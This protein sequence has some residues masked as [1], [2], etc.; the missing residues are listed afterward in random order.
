[1]LRDTQGVTVLIYDQQCAAEA[2]RKRKRGKLP[3]RRTRVVINEAVC[4]GCGDCGVK[5]NCLSVQP[6]DT[7]VRP[8]DAHRPDLLQH[9][10]HLPGRRLPVVRDGRPSPLRPSE[11]P[12]GANRGPPAG[13]PALDLRRGPARSN[14]FLAGIGGTGIVTVNQVLAIAALRAG[15]NVEGLDQTGLSQK[16]GPVTSHLRSSAGTGEP[17]N[18]LSPA[19]PTA[20]S[21]STCSPPPT[22]GPRLRRLRATVT[23]AS[24]SQTPDRRHGLRPG[25]AYPDEATLLERLARSRGDSHLRRARAAQTLFG[26]TAAANFLLVGAAYQAG[27]LPLPRRGDRG[28]HRD[29]RGRGQGQHGGV[30]VGTRRRR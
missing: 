16:A 28:G 8:Q 3:A 2:R 23:V 9:R 12:S 25:G 20:C 29:Q 24:T 5:S 13:G 30:P 1:M 14:V 26:N 10:L 27:G 4:E 17:S 22:P 21:P 6:V 19:P 11:K 7:E 18:R 15:C